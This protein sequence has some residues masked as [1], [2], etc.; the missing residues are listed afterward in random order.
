MVHSLDKKMCQQLKNYQ[1]LYAPF[2]QK[3]RPL[4]WLP[5]INRQTH[6]QCFPSLTKAR[7]R[8]ILHNKRNNL[9]YDESCNCGHFGSGNYPCVAINH[10]DSAGL[11][12]HALFLLLAIRSS[13]IMCI[14]FSFSLHD[15]TCCT[16][17][18]V[19]ELSYLWQ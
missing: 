16:L 10:T 8:K 4:Q 1:V 17:S 18:I 7:I 5:S 19:S 9:K 15:M 3:Y 6:M 12:M 14:R 13:I 2:V 11:Y